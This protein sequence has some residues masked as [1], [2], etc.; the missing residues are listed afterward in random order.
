[1]VSLWN[2]KKRGRKESPA[3][4]REG[5][6]VKGPDVILLCLEGGAGVVQKKKDVGALEG[7]KSFDAPK[8]GKMCSCGGKK[9]VV[10][11]LEKNFRRLS[12]NE[13]KGLSSK[14][15]RRALASP[16]ESRDSYRGER[17]ETIQYLHARKRRKH[18]NLPLPGKV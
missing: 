7:K 10:G 2:K 3:G 18:A 4:R 17:K 8:T 11:L 12:C 1:V 15:E 13:K 5:W 14:M 16:C 6:T 9:K